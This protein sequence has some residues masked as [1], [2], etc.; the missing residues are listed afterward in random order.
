MG[1]LP[2]VEGRAGGSGLWP[3]LEVNLGGLPSDLMGGALG[4]FPTKDYIHDT[5]VLKNQIAGGQ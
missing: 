5:Q 2:R 3:E 4:A 1:V